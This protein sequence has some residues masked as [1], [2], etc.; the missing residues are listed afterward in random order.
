MWNTETYWFDLALILGIFAVG[1]ILLG[2]F[3][4]HKPKWLRLLKVGVFIGVALG[5]SALQMRW[6]TYLV[7]ALFTMGAAYIHLVWLPGRGIDGWTG[8]PRQKY[9]QL[10]GVNQDSGNPEEPNPPQTR[11]NPAANID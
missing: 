8:Q 11:D 5:F 4:E 9:L 7:I 10:L 3:E 6:L 1:N 2:H